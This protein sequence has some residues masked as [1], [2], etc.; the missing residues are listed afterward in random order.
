MTLSDLYAGVAAI[1]VAEMRIRAICER[2]GAAALRAGIDALLRQG[3]L[4]SRNALRTL[5]KG[6]WE[7]QDF[8][9][10]D[11]FTDE[12]IPVR[13]RITVTDENFI[14]DFTGSSLQ[15]P[16]PVT[17]PGRGCSPRPA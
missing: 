13:V 2:H 14:A 15:R 4:V 16:G 17:A 6:S 12:P 3:E 8:M 9:D 11:G 10:D 5:P 7:A 1:R